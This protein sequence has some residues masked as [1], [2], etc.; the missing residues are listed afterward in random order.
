MKQTIISQKERLLLT[1]AI[2][3][4]NPNVFSHP[5]WVRFSKKAKTIPP[6]TIQALFREAE[7]LQRDHPG[8]ACQVWLICA[9]HLNYSGQRASALASIQK[10]LDL[11]EHSG[12]AQ[13]LLWA[14]WGACAICVQERNYEQAS[15]HFAHLQAALH[16]RNE[17][18]LAD[19]IDVLRQC[20][21]FSSTRG[22]EDFTQSA[23]NQQLECMLSLT[24]DWLQ[25][26]GY[27]APS[28]HPIALERTITQ[29]SPQELITESLFSAGGQPGPWH[30]LKLMF[31]G[32]LRLRWTRNDAPHTTGQPPFWASMLRRLRAYLFGR[33][34]DAGMTDAAAQIPASSPPQEV[35]NLPPGFST[36]DLETD[37]RNKPI[38]GDQPIKQTDA[39]VPVSVQMLGRFVMSIKDTE[40]KLPGSRSLSLL[41]YLMLH[42]KQTTPREVLMDVFWPDA[43][44]ETARNNLNVAMHG[45]RKA[46]HQVIDFPVILY[47]DGAY[48]IAPNLQVWLDVEEFERCVK[49]GQRLESR[50]QSAPVSE[51][52]TAVSIYQGDFLEENPYEEWTLLERER[53]RVTYLDTLDRL[54]QIYFSHE[55]Y[56]ACITACRHILSRDL[57]REDTHC[58]LM[59]CYSRQGQQH[60]ALRQ[61]QVCVEALRL[62]LDVSPAPATKQ[63]FEQIR[64]HRQV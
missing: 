51:Y 19:Y 45:I 27:S 38:Q 36:P 33:E 56:A 44:P 64:Q 24:Y 60:L 1:Y 46:L 23:D 43:A 32:E 57:C 52:E 18:V 34:T 15:I 31:R 7:G 12:L 53:L 25:Q 40:A 4:L 59:R 41:K 14:I 9:V 8:D 61:Y 3:K 16:E 39:V 47:R 21:P 37:S 20:F 22:A 49:T 13:E 48:S 6:E 42:H 50:N 10:A 17:W 62:E 30:T 28:D 35:V 54:S 26:W 63:L 11:A 5:V 58:L 55:Y 29:S 2:S